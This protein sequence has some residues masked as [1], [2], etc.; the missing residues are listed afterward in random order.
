MFKAGLLKFLKK[1][2]GLF[3]LEVKHPVNRLSFVTPMPFTYRG[4]TAG[5][6]L[7]PG[8][9]WAG[10]AGGVAMPLTMPY[11]ALGANA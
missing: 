3:A 11:P 9:A 7:S 4:K 5:E 10:V 2:E 6:T 1:D 8:C